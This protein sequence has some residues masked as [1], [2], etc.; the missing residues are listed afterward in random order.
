MI[1]AISLRKTIHHSREDVAIEMEENRRLA[2][3]IAFAF[4]NQQ[5]MSSGTSL[6]SFHSL[7]N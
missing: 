4:R 2:G 1:L 7:G 5:E 6:T 3:L